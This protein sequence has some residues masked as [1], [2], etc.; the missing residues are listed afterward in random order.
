MKIASSWKPRFKKDQ[1]KTAKFIGWCS[2][3]G[4]MI[5]HTDRECPKCGCVGLTDQKPEC[6][7]V[8]EVKYYD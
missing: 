5:N 6:K 4:L 7:E 1:T 8:M 2:G 3:C